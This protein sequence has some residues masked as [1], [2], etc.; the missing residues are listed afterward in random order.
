MGKGREGKGREGKGK[1]RKGKER[2]GKERKGKERKGK[3]KERK[4]EERKEGKKERRKEG[5]KERSLTPVLYSNPIFD[6]NNDP[7]GIHILNYSNS[8]TKCRRRAL[9]IE[10][11]L[12]KTNRRACCAS[13][14]GSNF[15][16]SLDKS[17]RSP[18]NSDF[19]K[20]R[21]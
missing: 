10:Y 5:K 11:F 8:S 7:W 17:G 16:L 13:L 9:T 18:P 3:E 14:N 2:K 19:R 21:G 6:C 20:T 1:E 4:G 15:F 12:G